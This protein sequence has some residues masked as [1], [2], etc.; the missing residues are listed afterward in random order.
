MIQALIPIGLES[1]REELTKEL[2]ELTGPRYA[3]ERGG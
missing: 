2:E 1:V 3:R